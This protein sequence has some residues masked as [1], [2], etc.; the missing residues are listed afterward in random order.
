M[1]WHTLKACYQ[2]YRNE[3]S[4]L[5]PLQKK[6]VARALQ[7]GLRG[8]VSI[9]TE[10]QEQILQAQTSFYASAVG[11]IRRELLTYEVAI[12]NLADTTKTQRRELVGIAEYTHKYIEKHISKVN[13]SEASNTRL[14]LKVPSSEEPAMLP[15]TMLT[16]IEA[17]IYRCEV[18]KPEYE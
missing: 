9:T 2:S 12:S 16:A 13:E 3:A 14:S 15:R 10:E 11:V 4:Q 8:R 18:C 6:N 1:P 17:C 7:A 5:N